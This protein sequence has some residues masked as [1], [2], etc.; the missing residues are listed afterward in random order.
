M[1]IH[2]AEFRIKPGF[3]AEVVAT[4]QHATP[5][6]E[7]PEGVVAHSVG[8]RL[9]Q[10]HRWHLM[11]C[12]W[13]DFETWRHA[14]NDAGSPICLTRVADKLDDRRDSVVDVVASAG[15]S[16]EE[17][18]VLRIYRARVRADQLDE[19]EA[20]AR[21]P[22]EWLSGRDGLVSIVVGPSWPRPESGNDRVV[23]AISAW[24]DWSD[25]LSATGGR[26]HAALLRTELSDLEQPIGAE[27]YELL[28]APQVE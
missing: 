27:H 25:V 18:R 2:L 16:W 11:A 3:E 5:G 7:R 22:V 14:L 9:G 4:L 21:G 10:S 1:I 23:F 12:A 19:W 8:R 28:E 17:G 15:P 6:G 24:R 13:R 26:I 20:R